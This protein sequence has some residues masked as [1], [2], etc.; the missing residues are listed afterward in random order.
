M[1]IAGRDYDVRAGLTVFLAISVASIVA[2]FL[3]T[4]RAGVGTSLARVRPGFLA[5]ACALMLGQ[6]CLNA[7]RF[8]VLVNSLGNNVSFLTSLKAFMANVFL[9]AITP[10]QTGGGPVQIYI[11]S[12]A[13]VPLATGFA[14]C[15]MG[16]VLSVVCLLTSTLVI[17]ILRPDLRAEF[18]GHLGG[19]LLVVAVVFSALAGLFLLSVFRIG[20]MKQLTGRAL[21]LA[22]RV[23]KTERRLAVTKRVLGGLDRYRE[24]LSVFARRK[25]AR[26]ALALGLT[27]AGIA[28]NSLIAPALLAGLGVGFNAQH[29][30]LAQFVLLFVA[31]FGPT[32][33]ASGIAEFAN[34]WMLM[35]LR[36]DPGV[37]GIYTVMWRFFT[38]YAGV[39][40]GGLVTLACIP[41]PGRGARS[42]S[43]GR[44]DNP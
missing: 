15:L 42:N 7:V 18:G 39:A 29:V 14:G 19:I 9:S 40:V 23:L 41:R 22:T 20:F 3:M 44:G 16:A 5:A 28:T 36:V 6:W 30:Y 37:L 10:S 11:L 1:R 33:G 35:S 17:M 2:I 24:C 21:L 12:R 13:G 25:K 34:Y 32:P 8:K 27:F 4:N 38:S 26:V 43:A 31:Y